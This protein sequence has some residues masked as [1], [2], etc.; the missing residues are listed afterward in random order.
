[1]SCRFGLAGQPLFFFQL[2][3]MGGFRSVERYPLSS[4]GPNRAL[5]RP[6]PPFFLSVTTLHKNPLPPSGFASHMDAR[7]QAVSSIDHGSHL[8]VIC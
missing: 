4:F 8:L 1:M 5:Q 3:C 6:H 7:I 2:L